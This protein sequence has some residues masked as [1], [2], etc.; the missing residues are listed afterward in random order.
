MIRGMENEGGKKEQDEREVEWE[1]V[2]NVIKILK[3]GKAMERNEI[4]NEA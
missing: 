2:R 3:D 4:P 1:E